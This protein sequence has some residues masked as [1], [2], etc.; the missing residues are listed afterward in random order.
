VERLPVVLALTPVAERAVEEVLFGRESLVEVV[1]SAADADELERD[2]ATSAA[3]SAL[4]SSDLSG[5]TPALCARVRACGVR[6]VGLA[7]DARERSQLQALGVDEIVGLTHSDEVFLS[8]L[9]GPAELV[10]WTDEEQDKP[11]DSLSSAKTG[12]VLAVIGSKGAP[13]ASECGASLA[14]LASLRWPSILVEVDALGGGLD[15]RLGADPRQGSLLGLARAV[16]RDDRLLGELLERWLVE[17]DGWPPALVGAPEPMQA[18]D[19]L[20]HPGTIAAA[21]RALATLRPLVIADTGFLLFEDDAA[22]P[23][24][25]VHREAVVTADAVLLVVGARE[26]QLRAGLDQLDALLALDVAPARL[27][28]TLNGAGGPGATA[29]ARLDSLLRTQLAERG[30][31]LDAWLVWDG[32]SL[33]RAQRTGRTLATARPR[34]AYARSLARLL[35]ELFLPVVPDSRGRKLRLAPPG[36]STSERVEEVVA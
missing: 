29:R 31:V 1:A 25:R 5:L 36:P 4:V 11:S 21:L 34:G 13:G 24:C 17:R 20:A 8:A 32:R 10:P 6:V 26:A 7:G 15:L 16:A 33:S 19:E 27:R 14:A 2:A 9:R 3:R 30:L 12:S 18:L 23:A 35:D 22:S 28:V